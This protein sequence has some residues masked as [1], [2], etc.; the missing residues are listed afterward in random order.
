MAASAA[1][2]DYAHLLVERFTAAA[3]VAPEVM[4]ETIVDFERGFATFDLDAGLK[5]VVAFKPDVVVLAIGENVVPPLTTDAAKTAFK[6]A[7]DRLL[8][9]LKQSGNVNIFV[10]SSFWPNATTDGI[11]REA[12][13]EAGGTF[14]DIERLS[15]DES[16]YA[17]SERNIDHKGV[18]EHP[19]DKGM[20]AIAEAIWAAIAAKMGL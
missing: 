1:D 2:K 7:M 10:R 19:G 13:R 15:Q 4:I 8:A 17:R 14:V 9:K 6:T 3:G 12:C 20:Q 16:N 11:M 5:K 18:A